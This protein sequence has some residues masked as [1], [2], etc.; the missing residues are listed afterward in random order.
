MPYKKVKSSSYR[1]PCKVRTADDGGVQYEE[2]FDAVFRRT[3]RAEMQALADRGDD[4][5]IRGV[6]LGWS[7]ILDESGEEIPFSEAARD[8]LMQDQS[9]CRAI[10]E[11][12]YQGV[13]GARAGN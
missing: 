13:N 12:F 3:P 5:L 7:G 2:T 4:H 8:E 11:G 6:L 1:W 10:I 9:W